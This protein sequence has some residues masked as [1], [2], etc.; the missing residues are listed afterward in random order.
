MVSPC[1]L[2]PLQAEARA[3]WKPSYFPQFT[4]LLLI[5]RHGSDAQIISNLWELA[6]EPHARG[7]RA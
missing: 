2:Q 4:V 6:R 7:A 1:E 3:T 5:S